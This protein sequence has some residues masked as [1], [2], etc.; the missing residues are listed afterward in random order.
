MDPRPGLAA[1]V[2]LCAVI[3]AC[4]SAPAS[5]PRPTTVVSTSASDPYGFSAVTW[6]ADDEAAAQWLDRL[7]EEVGGLAKVPAERDSSSFDF[8]VYRSGAEEDD[9]S[10]SWF[11]LGGVDGLVAVLGVDDDD[12]RTEPCD[13]WASSPSLDSLAGASGAVLRTAVRALP[14]TL[15]EPVPWWTCTFTHDETGEPLATADWEWY[16]TWVSGDRSFTVSTGS[17]AERDVL[18]AAAVQTAAG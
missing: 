12:D 7:P 17:E 16:A 2:A 11:A 13:L 5:S 14:E 6:P 10:V 1:A 15:P 18:V 9:R 8:V 4:T 3:T